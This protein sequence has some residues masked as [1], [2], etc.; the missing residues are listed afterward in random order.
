MQKIQEQ[1]R[2]LAD[3]HSSIEKIRKYFL[4][5]LIITVATVILPLLALVFIIP[6]FLKIITS[7]LSI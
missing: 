4:W 5:T 2:K 1:D 7:S 6:W 3:I